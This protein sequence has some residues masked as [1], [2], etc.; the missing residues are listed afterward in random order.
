MEDHQLFVLAS[1]RLQKLP[2]I[3]SVGVV[4]NEERLEDD[5]GKDLASLIAESVHILGD[6]L[7]T[8]KQHNTQH[9]TVTFRGPN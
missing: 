3:G 2:F 9:T 6:P 5:L 4:S 8:A 1:C 7:V